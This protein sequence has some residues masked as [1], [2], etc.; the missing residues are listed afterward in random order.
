[1]ATYEETLRT[2]EEMRSRF[3]SGFSSS[4]KMKIDEL[5]LLICGKR[6]KNTGCGDCY[7]D[8]FI[9]TRLKL[10]SMK[11]LP[12]KPNYILKAGCI[13]H[14]QGTSK[15]YSLNN[16][17][18]EAA[19][20]HLAKFPHDIA[21]F[22]TYPTDW[23]SRVKARQDGTVHIPTADE[24]KDEVEKLSKEIAEKDVRIEEL[25]GKSASAN[26]AF[27]K[28]K[29]EA[30]AE[31]ADLHDKLE[32]KDAEIDA[33]VSAA[34]KEVTDA[35]NKTIAELKK[36]A[37]TASDTIAKQKAEIEKLKADLDAAKK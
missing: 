9:E 20:N 35:M 17:T 16:V 25:E 12:E 36:E 31:V 30:Q 21:M 29:A 32:K 14:P 2:L 24:L 37:L 7:R 27:E 28:C 11:K 18:D 19:E 22:E 6:V 4:D 10:K 23:E 15:F 8:A 3:H 5:Y 34:K 1:M 13:I 33:A 26:E